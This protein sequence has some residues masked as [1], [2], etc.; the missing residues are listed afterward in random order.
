[1]I[2]QNNNKTFC[3]NLEC[4]VQEE[5]GYVDYKKLMDPCITTWEIMA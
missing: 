2:E 3:D 4:D 1:M 5:K